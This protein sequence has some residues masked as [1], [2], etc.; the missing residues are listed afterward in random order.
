M[1]A[2]D[3]TCAAD[4]KDTGGLGFLIEPIDVGDEIA[5]VGQIEI[6]NAV[7]DAGFRDLIA[8]LLKWPGSVHE[9]IGLDPAQG[10]IEIYGDVECGPFG[11]QFFSEAAGFLGRAPRDDQGD[12]GFVCKSLRDEPAEIA[13]TADKENAFGHRLRLSPGPCH[14][15]EE[16][17]DQ[18]QKSRPTEDEP[19]TKQP[20]IFAW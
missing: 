6:V 3:R 19:Q 13:V 17:G 9:D 4:D 7:A 12:R 1:R 8:L 11:V 5:P 16:D 20:I 14:H 2:G 10:Q 15:Q 18:S